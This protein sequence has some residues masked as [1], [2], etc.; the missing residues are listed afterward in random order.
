MTIGYKKCLA[1]NYKE[2]LKKETILGTVRNKDLFV[3]V[4]LEIS[5]DAKTFTPHEAKSRTEYA[6]VVKIHGGGS[7]A[8]SLFD[9]SFEYKVGETVNPDRFDEDSN[10]ECS[11]G[12]HFFYNKD[13]AI[14]YFSNSWLYIMD[15][16]IG[17]Y[18]MIT[19]TDTIVDDKR[20]TSKRK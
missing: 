16:N 9:N 10:K 17:Q 1:Y 14:R 5:D 3:L 11:S 18:V 15:N 20:I 12:I 6:K 2:I 13:M 8:Y 4:E 19:G 7:V